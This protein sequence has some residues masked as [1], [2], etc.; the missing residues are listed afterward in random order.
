MVSS[1]APRD[2]PRSDSADRTDP[3]LGHVFLDRY[4]VVRKLEARRGGGLYLAQHLL[5][6]RAVTVEVLEAGPAHPAAV[7]HCLEDARTVA[8]VGH[9]NVVDIFNGGRTPEGGVFLV[10]APLEG[11]DL[12]RVLATEA[13][14][15]WDRA[16]GI[17]LQ[18]A[19]A[20]SAVHRHGVVHGELC[21]ENVRLV[22]RDGRREL[23]KLLG[24]GA[25]R[26]RKPA[27][28]PEAA[29]DGA[30]TIKWL[31]PEQTRGGAFDHRADVYALGC[32]AYELVTGEPP[33]VATTGAALSFKQ[34]TETPAPPTSRRPA[35]TL[36]SELDAVV[37]RALEPDPARRWPDAAAF[38]DAIGRCR[39]TRRQSGRVEALSAAEQSGK[40]D[41]FEIDARGRRRRAALLSVAAAVVI[42]TAVVRVITKAPGHVR[43]S[44]EPADAALTFNGLAVTARAPVVLEAAPGRYTLTVSRPG[45]ATATRA[46]DVRARATVSVPVTLEPEARTAAATPLATQPP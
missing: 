44:T 7:D 34:E 4:R 6:E 32:L 26:L 22:P 15:L 29:G 3:M 10:M 46:V 23:V 24:F 11:D 21:P 13:P 45:Y 33:F 5:A 12:A 2:T 9:E 27:I 25:W 20:L 30:T 42:A 17:V 39:R 36:P 38:A 40:T 31:A 37:L 14:L 43:I 19:D 8:R 28:F 35:G 1:D 18:V 41:A 16:K